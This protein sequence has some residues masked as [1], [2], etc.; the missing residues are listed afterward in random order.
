MAATLRPRSL[1]VWS[2]ERLWFA[3]AATSSCEMFAAK[4]G[5]PSTPTSIVSVRR[6][7]LSMRSRRNANSSPL[8]SNVPISATV[9][10]II[11]SDLRQLA[12]SKHA[13]LRHRAEKRLGARR[14]I[15]SNQFQRLPARVHCGV[16]DVGGNVNHISGADGLPLFAVDIDHLPAKPGD[17]VQHLFRARVIVPCVAFPRLQEHNPHGESLCAGDTRFTEPL[18]RSPIKDLR[19]DRGRCYETATGEAGHVCSFSCGRCG[20]LDF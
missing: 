10:V 7:A 4:R 6:P 15:D 18:D 1:S 11:A 16:V 13:A 19:F 20:C 8:V 5:L 3:A 9:L 14:R 12:R 2:A 17:Y